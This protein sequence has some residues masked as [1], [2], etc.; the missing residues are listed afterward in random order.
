MLQHHK[1]VRDKIPELIHANGEIAITRQL[2]ETDYKAALET[3]LHEEVAEFCESHE[4]EELADILEVVY[5]L[6]ESQGVSEAALNEIRQ[7]KRAERGGFRD[8]IFLIE[9]HK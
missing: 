4:P 3:K 8:K 2:S 6:A 7:H 9:T 1:L 5:T